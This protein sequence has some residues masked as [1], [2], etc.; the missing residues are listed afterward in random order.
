MKEGGRGGSCGGAKRQQENNFGTPCKTR[1]KLKGGGGA[2]GGWACSRTT[3][4]RERK[5]GWVI[6]ML[7]QIRAMPRWENYLVWQSEILGR[8]QGTPRWAYETVL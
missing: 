1:G 7:V 5:S 2:V 4:G 8:R 3:T 6:G